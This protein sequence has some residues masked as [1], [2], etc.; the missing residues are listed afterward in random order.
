MTSSWCNLQCKPHNQ[1]SS[2]MQHRRGRPFSGM[3]M[4]YSSSI[5]KMGGF[6][7][8]LDLVELVHHGK[9]FKLN[10]Y[11]M[12]YIINAFFSIPWESGNIWNNS[13]IYECM[14]FIMNWCQTLDVVYYYNSGFSTV[15]SVL[16]FFGWWNSIHETAT[17]FCV[18]QHN[19]K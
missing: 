2:S 5:L 11:L 1:S 7:F 8:K 18:R 10:E 13:L 15:W 6:P 4:T 19:E 16:D 3:L 17:A 12:K 9:S 14:Y